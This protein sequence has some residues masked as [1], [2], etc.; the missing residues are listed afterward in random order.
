MKSII[1]K[2]I[3]KYLKSKLVSFLKRRDF[4]KFKKDANVVTLKFLID[5]ISKTGINEGDTV[6]LQSSLKGLGYIENG[7]A[8][9]I[10]AFK[11]VI[12][13]KGTLVL[14]TFTVPISMLDTLSNSE[15]VFNKESSVSSTGAITN[16]FLK[17]EG[18]Y[19]SI[20]PT[21]SV[22]AWG[23]KAEFITNSHYESGCNFGKGTPFEKLLDLEA[24]I[25]GLAVNY[26]I[27]TFYHVYEDFNLDKF[28]KVYLPNKFDAKLINKEGELVISKTY[29]HNP[30]FHKTRI[31]KVPKTESFFADYY[32]KNGIS[33]RTEIGAGFLWWIDANTLL[34][35]L[36]KLYKENITV[37]NID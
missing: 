16:A 3:P 36:D 8:D 35:E 37:Y 7:P 27:I 18:V 23:N 15:N 26:G 14:P 22:T 33:H 31:D 10:N 11:E 21:H 2:L 13:K 29:C 24:K 19:R 32:I 20:H 6:Y 30:E 28:P 12:G 9:I 25:V 1:S 17:T 5:E 4:D 34:K